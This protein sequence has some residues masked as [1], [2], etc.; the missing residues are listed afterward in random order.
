MMNRQISAFLV[1]AE[2]ELNKLSFNGAKFVKSLL[3]SL[4]I[5]LGIIALVCLDFSKIYQR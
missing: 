4:I 3:N 5:P 1:I 2:R